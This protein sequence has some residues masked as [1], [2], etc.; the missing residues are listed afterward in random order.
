MTTQPYYAIRD[1][2]KYILHCYD[3]VNQELIH[4]QTQGNMMAPICTR[5][6]TV[7]LQNINKLAELLKNESN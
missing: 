3:V 5:E 6:L 1:P 2:D 4:A 7:V